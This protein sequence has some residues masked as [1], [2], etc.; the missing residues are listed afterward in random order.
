MRSNQLS[1]LPVFA[2]LLTMPLF[3]A[4][5]EMWLGG[6]AAT[7]ILFLIG[8]YLFHR[9]SRIKTVVDSYLASCKPEDSEKGLSIILK[10]GVIELKNRWELNEVF[11]KIKARGLLHPDQHGDIPNRKLLR[12][13]KFCHREGYTLENDSFVAICKFKGIA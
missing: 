1:L 13:F 7:L 3:M 4:S 9:H 5:V 11:R 10:C 6:L 12:Y 2:W 8:Q